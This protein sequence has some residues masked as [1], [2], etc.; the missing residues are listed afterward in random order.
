MQVNY[1]VQVVSQEHFLGVAQ[2]VIEGAHY[3]S[4][5][6]GEM[7]VRLIAV[8]SLYTFGLRVSR[9]QPSHLPSLFLIVFSSACSRWCIVVA[10]QQKVGRLL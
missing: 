10:A 7:S 4:A 1:I 9:V 3:D 5:E 8:I 6:M 2:N